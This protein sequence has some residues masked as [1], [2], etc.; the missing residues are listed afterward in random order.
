[1]SM[2]TKNEVAQSYRLDRHGI[3]SQPG[4]FEGEP[5]YVVA[6][7][8]LALDSWYDRCDYDGD[9]EIVSFALDKELRDAIGVEAEDPREFISLTTRD[10]GF[11]CH[12]F[13]FECDLESLEGVSDD[14]FNVPG[15]ES[16]AQS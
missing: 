12:E 15:D 7:Y 5:W 16:E 14:P 10:D 11:V 8:D 4:K 9:T 3:V 6:L 2:Q 13:T 1:M